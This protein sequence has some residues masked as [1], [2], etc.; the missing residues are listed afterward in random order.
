MNKF[1]LREGLDNIKICQYLSLENFLNQLMTGKYYVRRKDLFEDINERSLPINFLFVPTGVDSN[2]ELHVK[3]LLNQQKIKFDR[4][5]ELSKSFVSCWTKDTL[6]NYFMWK[7]Y[8]STYGVRIMSSIKKVIASFDNHIF[9]N[10][11]T[12]VSDVLYRKFHYNDKPE[13]S[14]FVKDPLY[15]MEQEIRFIFLPKDESEKTEDNILLSYK[16]EVMI[17]EVLLSPFLSSAA[18]TFIK[19]SLTNMFGLKVRVK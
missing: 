14:L 6:S 16:Y 1:Y 3:D 13:D 17:D 10:Y 7:V 18:S 15:R 5:K 11:E 2:Q 8:A 4:F 9:K 19:D 12:Y